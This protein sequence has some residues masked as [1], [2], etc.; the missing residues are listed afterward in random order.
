MS[1]VALVAEKAT[2]AE[3][4]EWHITAARMKKDKDREMVLRKKIFN[5]CFPA[6]E[7]GTNTTEIFAGWNLK[8]THKIDRKPKEELLKTFAEELKAAELPL[9]DLIKMKPELSVTAYK[10]LSDEQ[11]KIFDKVL[12]IKPGA[13]SIEIVKQKA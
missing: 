8:A 11:R 4:D 3:I 5:G 2:Q 12:E 7:E 13:P 6:P 9:S 1:D 10:K